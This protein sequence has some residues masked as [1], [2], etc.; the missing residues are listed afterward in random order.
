MKF[1][2]Y[3]LEAAHLKHSAIH[4]RGEKRIDQ[5]KSLPINEIPKP[6]RSQHDTCN[7]SRGIDHRKKC[8]P[9]PCQVPANSIAR[10]IRAARSEG[11]S[12][13]GVAQARG[14]SDKNAGRD[15]PCLL[16][17]FNLGLNPRESYAFSIENGDRPI[18]LPWIRPSSWMAFLLKRCPELLCGVKTPVEDTLESFWHC[19]RKVHPGH[20]I[21][22]NA[23]PEGLSEKLRHTIPLA[24]HGDEGRYLKKSFYMICTVESLLGS[25]GQ[26]ALKCS[27]CNDP[28]LQRYPD[29][30]GVSQDQHEARARKQVPQGKGHSYLSK[31]LCFGMASKQYKECP[32]LLSKA[33]E[34][35]STDLRDLCEHGVVVEGK[36]TFYGGF[37]GVKGDMKFHHQV[38]HLSQS[39]YNLGRRHDYAICHLC[40]AGSSGLSWESLE[41]SPAWAPRKD[42][43]PPALVS[44]PFDP[45][46]KSAVFRLD[47][48]DLWKVG[49]GRDLCGSGGCY[50]VLPWEIRFRAGLC[51][52]H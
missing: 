19:Y 6:R 9:G 7:P 21:F 20:S 26:V 24:L 38:G 48:F 37:L 15:V 2:L 3:S 22:E 5:P 14:M 45:M 8:H 10:N 47:P 41:D 25:H 51:S 12:T 33:F 52:E 17:R 39:Y 11:C 23:D 13:P 42:E 34:L 35:V 29:L 4:V 36:G 46:Q 18:D 1:V 32:G 28:V 31:F 30:P 27:S 44:V 49:L 50:P 16:S 40:A 43:Q